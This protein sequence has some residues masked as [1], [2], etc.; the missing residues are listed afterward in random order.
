MF[1]LLMYYMLNN[2]MSSSD[3]IESNGM[4]TGE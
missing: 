3:Y 1:Y 2:G 4:V